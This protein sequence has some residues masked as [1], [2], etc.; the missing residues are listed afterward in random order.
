M[1]ECAHGRR[2]RGERRPGC[3]R[4]AR[5]S[6][7][8]SRQRPASFTVFRVSCEVR[9]ETVTERDVGARWKPLLSVTSLV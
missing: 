3:W 8:G 5:L 6:S 7:R 2:G 4:K 1:R 9:Q